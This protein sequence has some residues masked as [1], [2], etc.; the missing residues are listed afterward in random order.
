ML[1]IVDQSFA[2]AES[3]GKVAVRNAA[4]RI[5]WLAQLIILNLIEVYPVYRSLSFT[6]FAKVEAI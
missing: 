3:Q 2:L 1:S 5:R 6:D 4:F